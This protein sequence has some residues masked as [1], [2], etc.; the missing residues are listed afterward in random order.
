MALTNKQK[1]LINKKKDK[2]S[3]AEIA[4][5]LEL[6]KN[7]VEA[8]I[9]TPTKKTPSWFYSILI[10]LPVVV[11]LMLEIGLRLLG[12]GRTYDQWVPLGN[13]KLTL[14]PDIAYRYFYSSERA[15][16]A[17]YNYL[18]EIKKENS[19][20]VFIMGGSSAA[21]FPYTPNGSFARYI[22]KRLELLYPDRNIEVVNIAMSA[23]N[24]YALRDMLPEV[25]QMKPDLIVIYAGHNEY[26]GALGVGSVETLGDT[27][28]IVNTVIW[29]NRFKTFEILRDIIK[30]LS[31]LFSSP[32]KQD[33]TLMARMSQ[34]Q[35]IPYNSEKYYAGINQLEENLRDMLKMARDKNV[36]VI[37]GR[38]VSNLKDQKPFE[39]LM[40]EKYP[41]AGD[42][43]ISA[44][45][46]L[47][48][49][50]SIIADSLFRFTKDLD[51]LRWRAPEK[52]NS[53]IESL[54]KEF[55][56]PVVKFDSVFNAE[57]KSGVVGDNLFTDHL[58]PN[59][60]GYQ[61]IGREFFNKCLE[62]KIFPDEGLL[63]YSFAVQDSI[64]LSKYEFTKLDS[65]IA[66]YQIIILKSDWPYTK[67]KLSDNEKLKALNMRTYSD[68]LAYLVGKG[69]LA[70]EA[71]HLQLAQRRLLN[72][73]KESFH[74]EISACIDEYPFDPYPPEFAAQQLINLKDF[75][76]AYPYLRNLSEINE[77]AY[78][79]KW[80]GIIDLL[81]NKVDSAIAYL[82]SSLNYN[83]SDSQVLYNLA[84]AYSI[85]R[86][87]QTA[88][89][90]INRCLQI[91]PN[92]SM[93]KSLQQQLINA[94]RSNR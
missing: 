93:A 33:G 10:L 3:A 84:G 42:I 78:S 20:R 53:V 81:N 57:T 50:K 61:I 9:E 49:G 64:T 46:E 36:P 32:V 4:K 91:E 83:S 8:F 72:G 44:Q 18:D 30:S 88:L 51:A 23:I 54:G 68:T 79:T 74:K 12:Y 6:D 87:Y 38:L 76:E 82:T 63:K 34:R 75:S 29:L 19:L 86:D 59:L 25:I 1:K 24:S 28:F 47:A 77:S 56:Y 11:V 80:L 7:L 69:D 89:Q 55:N 66:E 94:T 73:D 92:Y 67:E 90:M 71:A 43:F 2:L 48:K 45:K 37:L 60:R 13:G 16:S 14:N 21:G 22:R 17:G 5:E 31:D 52:F 65:T 35:L 58:H 39:S 70:W 15:P 85:K 40:D 62:A 27:R 41:N 26:Y